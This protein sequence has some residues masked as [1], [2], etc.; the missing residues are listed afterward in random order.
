MVSG[1]GYFWLRGQLEKKVGIIMASMLLLNWC[2]NSGNGESPIKS[3]QCFKSYFHILLR[4]KSLQSAEGKILRNNS[5]Q[6][7]KIYCQCI[8]VSIRGGINLD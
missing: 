2:Y 6:N 4:V 1:K 8:M 3:K 5:P 7:I